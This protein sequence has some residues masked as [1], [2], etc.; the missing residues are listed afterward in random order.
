[1]AAAM[2]PRFSPP[3]Q[4]LLPVEL[5]L[6]LLRPLLIATLL[7]SLVYLGIGW[8]SQSGTRLFPW[9]ALGLLVLCVVCAWL[10][11]RGA[12]GVIL[13]ASLL[14]AGISQPF[15]YASQTFGVNHPINATFV[16]GII[17]CGLLVGGWFLGFWTVGYSAWLLLV[18]WGEINGYWTPPNPIQ[19]WAQMWPVLA[20]W[21]TLFALTGG[22]VWLFARALERAALTA[23]GQ[24]GLL[25]RTLNTLA[26]ERDLAQLPSQVVS[27]IAQQLGA[28]FATL[29]LYYPE[30][31]VLT[32][33]IGYLDGQVL[34]GEALSGKT[35]QQVPVTRLPI[36][37]DMCQLRRPI[38]V[39]DVAREPRL[40]NRAQMLAQGIRSVLYVPLLQEQTLLGM[41]AINRTERHSF[42]ADEVALAQALIQQMTLAMQLMR[43][44][45]E[46]RQAAILEERNRMAR[47]MHDTLAQGFTG[48]VVQLETAED[49]LGE[50]PEVDGAR[51]H[52]QRARTLA[53]TSLAEA[54]R[55]VWALRPGVLE[56]QPFPE[57]LR[58]TIEALTE[59]AGLAVSWQIEPALPRLRPELENDL[60]RIAQEAT[61]NAIKYAQAK[62]LTLTLQ[63]GQ[64]ALELQVRDDGQGFKP[65]PVASPPHDPTLGGF[66]LLGMRARATRHGG[67][68]EVTSAATGTCV[69]ARVPLNT[70]G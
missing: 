50:P 55:S 17:L 54:R 69:S 4:T 34:E 49:M 25:V 9:D 40:V 20:F 11:T 57:A 41:L 64:G 51:Q 31:D 63:Q 62:C 44:A 60:L 52:L 65:Q 66:G 67:T 68:L 18:A 8:A 33:Q 32:G 58:A 16:L 42:S 5:R 6:Q 13:A 39:E 2:R 36:W 70:A 3:T 28:R 53:R 15:F 26:S 56:H 35:L 45:E 1:M 47:E 27:A 48:I 21:W 38:V 37:Q 61:T 10:S 29:F 22:A 19:A 59:P 46:N 7:A 12:Q 43:L 30:Q 24:T 14:L 23:R